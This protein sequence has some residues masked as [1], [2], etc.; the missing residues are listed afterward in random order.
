MTSPEPTAPATSTTPRRNRRWVLPTVAALVVT[1][2]IGYGAMQAGANSGLEPK[3]AEQILTGMQAAEIKPLAGTVVATADLGL[4]AIPGAADSPELMSLVSG[5]HTVRVWYGGPE[6]VRIAK[7]GGA[8]ET[9]V[10]RNGKDAW[11]WSSTEKKA[12]HHTV[13]TGAAHGTTGTKDPGAAPSGMPT[14]PQEASQE[15]LSHLSEDSTVSTT[16]NSTVAGRD[17]YELVITP[18]QK[19]TLVKDVRLAV[20]GETMMPLRVQVYSTKLNAP[21]YEIGFTSLDLGPVEDR[22]FTFSP[23]S[24]TTVE[25]AG[26]HASG[27]DKG[28]GAAKSGEVH[29][30]SEAHK[31]G[32]AGSGMTSKVV[33][34]GW[35]RVY[36]ASTPAGALEKA[37]QSGSETSDGPHGGG[38]IDPAGIL[39]ALPERSGSWGK[40][41]VLD[42]TLFSAVLADDGRVAIG[43]VGVD[44]L[45]A[46]LGQGR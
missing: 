30:K 9:N 41:R 14:T 1:G 39:A 37:A 34:E 24:G 45:T 33:G 6:Q 12:V 25:E 4:P 31:K 2:G 35:E 36:V 26:A 28:H 8:G 40:G 7:L 18:K 13:P 23:P 19:N 29:K 21:A 22:M 43:A 27:D 10:I 38:G 15:I 20:D 11:I 16:S 5:S 3:T 42:G 32:E 44:Q 17:A 46:A